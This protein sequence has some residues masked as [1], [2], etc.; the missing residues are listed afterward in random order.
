MIRAG[1]PSTSHHPFSCSVSRPPPTARPTLRDQPTS[2][3]P[4]RLR[5]RAPRRA[6]QESG[7]CSPTPLAGALLLDDH[8]T[9]LALLQTATT[10]QDTGQFREAQAGSSHPSPA[11]RVGAGSPGRGRGGGGGSPA[12]SHLRLCM[13]GMQT[14]MKLSG[15]CAQGQRSWEGGHPLSAPCRCPS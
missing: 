3:A 1:N 12:F 2:A 10:Q 11:P 15:T 14:G 5:G 9:S 13:C 6:G 4:R 8:Q 7:F